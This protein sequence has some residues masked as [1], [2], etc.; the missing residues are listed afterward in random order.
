MIRGDNERS[1]LGEGAD[2]AIGVPIHE[3]SAPEHPRLLSFRQSPGCVGSQELD[4][5]D[6]P[7]E[8][9]IDADGIGT[10]GAVDDRVV[11]HAD[12]KMVE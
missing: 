9:A 7:P 11:V 3:P 1:P 2:E 5:P 6:P 4:E 10:S 12:L 8:G